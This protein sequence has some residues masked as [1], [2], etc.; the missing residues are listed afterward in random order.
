M[1][2]LV[3]VCLCVCD[4]HDRAAALLVLAPVRHQLSDHRVPVVNV[5][6]AHAP[7]T[8]G[9]VILKCRCD[10]TRFTQSRKLTC[11]AP[12]NTADFKLSAC[13]HCGVD[14]MMQSVRGG[15]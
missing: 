13:V 10:V 3:C 7:T 1:C 9:N 4:Y 5:M 12:A 2:V 6:S 11:Q 8:Q 15:V 14:S